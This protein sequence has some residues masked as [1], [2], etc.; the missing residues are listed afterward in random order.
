MVENFKQALAH[1]NMLSKE[2]SKLKDSDMKNIHMRRKRQEM[3]RK[4]S[5]VEKEL[6]DADNFK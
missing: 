1:K 2:R 3:R 4:K 5:I 6:Q